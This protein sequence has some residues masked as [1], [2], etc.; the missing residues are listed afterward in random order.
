[1]GE[2]EGAFVGGIDGMYVGTVDG[3][4]VVGIYDGAEEGKNVGVMEG[5]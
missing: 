1:M 2:G 3:E 5:E 4:Q